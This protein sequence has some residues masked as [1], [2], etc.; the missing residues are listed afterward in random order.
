MKNYTPKSKREAKDFR[1]AIKWFPIIGMYS[2]QRLNEIAGIRLKDIGCREGI[3]YFDLTERHIKNKASERLVPLH[4]KLISYGLLGFVKECRERGDT[5]LFQDLHD[6]RKN[7]GRDGFGEPISKWFNRTLLKNIGIDKEQE[8]DE[9]YLIDFH[10][11]RKTVLN[12]FKDQGVSS[13]IV[14][15]LVGHDIEDD[16]TFDSTYGEGAV[17]QLSVLKRVIERIDY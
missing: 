2:G 11:L 5:Y 15:Q 9:L 14:R 12:T 1:D 7:A 10:C 6:K 3:H 17:T 13:Y 4:S 8:K 16:I